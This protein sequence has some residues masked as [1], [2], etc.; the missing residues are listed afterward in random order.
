[1]SNEKNIRES[2]NE[3]SKELH[4]SLLRLFDV[5]PTDPAREKVQRDANILAREAILAIWGRIPHDHGLA[6]TADDRVERLH[7]ELCAALQMVTFLVDNGV[8]KATP[9]DHAVVVAGLKKLANL[10]SRIWPGRK[11]QGSSEDAVT[12]ARQ[13]PV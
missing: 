5:E 13:K 12:S 4:D 6:N 1:M 2:V 11:E 7:G 8:R 10:R 9:L 3:I